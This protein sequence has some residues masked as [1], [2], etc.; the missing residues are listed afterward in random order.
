[1]AKPR[2]H[3]LFHTFRGTEYEFRFNLI[4]PDTSVGIM[5]Y[6]AEEMEI[7]D[8]GTG[9]RQTELEKTVTDAEWE[10][11]SVELADKTE[12]NFQAEPEYGGEG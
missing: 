5:G 3:S 4:P 8:I 7:Y 2:Q 9:E 6:S 12:D 10:Q 1:M 11:L